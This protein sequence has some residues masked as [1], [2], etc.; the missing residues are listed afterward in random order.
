M[1]LALA[2]AL[3]LSLPISLPLSFFRLVLSAAATSQNLT[4]AAAPFLHPTPFIASTVALI[5][6]LTKLIS[7]PSEVN[8]A[9][10]CVSR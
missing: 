7:N 2:L 4:P 5:Q 8:L 1:S 6:H 9:N 10:I 3:A